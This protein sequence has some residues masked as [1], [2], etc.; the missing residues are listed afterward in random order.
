MGQQENIKDL[1][2]QLS[3]T[4]EEIYSKICTVVSVDDT[5]RTCTVRPID[6]SAEINRVKLQAFINGKTGVYLQPA[7]GSEVIVT[8]IGKSAAY[9]AMYSELDEIFID[10]PQ[11]TINGGDNGGLINIGDLV[12]KINALES[13]LNTVKGLFNAWVPLVEIPLKTA[14]TPW[15]AQ[16]FTPTLTAELEDTK[17]K[18]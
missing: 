10:V 11:I 14:L 17:V 2:R 8:F 18:H 12:S 13:D 6:E 16:I 3:D 1:I 4:G 7:E 15:A 9:V 5:K